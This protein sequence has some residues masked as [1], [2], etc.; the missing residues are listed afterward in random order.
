MIFQREMK[1]EE[2]EIGRGNGFG[3]RIFYE[4]EEEKKRHN[5]KQ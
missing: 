2:K 1:R 4:E 5:K 3:V